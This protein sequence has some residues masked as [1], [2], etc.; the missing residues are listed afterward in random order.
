MRLQ[1]FSN[2]LLPTL[3]ALLLTSCEE[4]NPLAPSTKLPPET[5]IGANTFG[6]LVNGK[7]WRNGG[8]FNPGSSLN[9]PEM[10][11]SRLQIAASRSVRDTLSSIGLYVFSSNISTG[12]YLC[13]SLNV[14]V[15]FLNIIGGP[16]GTVYEYLYAHEGE[17]EITRYDL[18]NRIVSGRFNA[19]LKLDGNDEIIITNGRFDLKSF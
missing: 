17:I 9:I 15:Y 16:T 5:T 6:C 18:E 7:I 3:L 1:K 19:K 12:Q 10:S 13:D 11:G 8:Y 14:N 2:L 4:N